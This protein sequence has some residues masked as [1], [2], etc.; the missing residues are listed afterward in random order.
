MRIIIF[1]PPHSLE[2][3]RNVVMYPGRICKLNAAQT[4]GIISYLFKWT[5]SHLKMLSTFDRDCILIFQGS[6]KDRL[7]LNS[8]LLCLADFCL[9]WSNCID[10]FLHSFCWIFLGPKAFSF[11]ALKLQ[12]PDQCL[13]LWSLKFVIWHWLMCK[14]ES[15]LSVL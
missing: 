2:V 10:A 13:N 11:V 4:N 1:A 6:P 15:K 5:E 12:F 14:F 8:S 9:R 7:N 3:K